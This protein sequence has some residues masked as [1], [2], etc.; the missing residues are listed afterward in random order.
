MPVN[1]VFMACC[2]FLAPCLTAWSAGPTDQ[3][4]VDAVR[5]ARPDTLAGVTAASGVAEAQLVDDQIMGKTMIPPHRVEFAFDGAAS[6][7]RDFD[8]KDPKK[9]VSATLVTRGRRI[10]YQSGAGDVPQ[11][12][13]ISPIRTSVV[14][15]DLEIPAWNYPELTRIPG[16]FANEKEFFAT[17]A[18]KPFTKVSKEGTTVAISINFPVITGSGLNEEAA[19][20]EFDMAAGGLVSRYHYVNDSYTGAARS[21]EDSTVLM[22]WRRA[23]NSFVPDSRD[24][25]IH[26]Q[27]AG[28]DSGSAHAHIDFKEFNIGPVKEEDLSPNSL[29][30]PP[31]TIIQD[32]ASHATYRYDDEKVDRMLGVEQDKRVGSQE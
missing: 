2:I 10:S 6:I 1:R 7:W 13:L 17:W 24:V 32:T 25:V 15:I 8:A 21:R 28:K 22:K 19:K 29:N 3:S 14:T 23:A 26:F 5:D 16:L 31:G 4:L 30:I 20:I 18:Q 27:R 11:S 9:L 12:V